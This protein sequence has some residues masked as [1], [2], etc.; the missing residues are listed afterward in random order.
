MTLNGAITDIDSVVDAEIIGRIYCPEEQANVRPL[1][2]RQCH[3][4]RASDSVRAASS[5]SQNIRMM[6]WDTVPLTHTH[7]AVGPVVWADSGNL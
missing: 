7:S 1:E 5:P 3:E 6:V 2:R 4:P